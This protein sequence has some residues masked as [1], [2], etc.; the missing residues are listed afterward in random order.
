MQAAYSTILILVQL[1][2][3]CQYVLLNCGKK[4]EKGPPKSNE[5][6]KVKSAMREPT[7][8]A[9]GNETNTPS[10][11]NN[12]M[13]KENAKKEEKQEGEEKKKDEDKAA[14]SMKPFPKFVMPTESTKKKREKQQEEDKQKKIKAGFYQE[15]SGEDDTL[16]KVKSLEVEKSDKTKRSTKKKK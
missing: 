5:S 3:I 2:A 16:E 8:S 12:D 6:M 15:N 14:Q 13:S 11:S 7:A 1:I 10:K 9:T 4:K